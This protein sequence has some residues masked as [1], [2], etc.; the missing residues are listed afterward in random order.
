MK[1]Y[2]E[3]VSLGYNCEVSFRLRDYFGNAFSSYL[4]TWTY[5]L[6]RQKFL[7]CIGGDMTRIMSGKVNY[8]P[9]SGGMF[10]DEQT[11]LSLHSLK[12][13][14]EIINGDGTEN[15]QVI[16]EAIS[17][18]RSRYGHLADKTIDLFLSDKCSLF[19]I[20]IRFTNL[21]EDV[22]FIHDL[23]LALKNKYISGKFD[24]L[25]VV[26]AEHEAAI[27]NEIC[28][29]VIVRSVPFF[30]TDGD[31]DTGGD[32]AAW[33]KIFDEFFS[34]QDYKLYCNLTSSVIPT[35]YLEWL[36]HQ[37]EEHEKYIEELHEGTEFLA[38]Q[39]QQ[40]KAK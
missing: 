6:D 14:S 38:K 24:L 13:D 20:K 26:E 7:D 30:S 5:M 1:V 21:D 32:H 17:E 34:L 16:S 27:R 19:V 31:T 25:V 22:K 23:Y 29:D 4:F 15:T 33:N 8:H 10:I 37:N 28:K 12:Q 35:E 9:H 40:L 36:K 11:G 3:I 39:L 18:M 2:D